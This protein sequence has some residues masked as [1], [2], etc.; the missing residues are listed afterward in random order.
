MNMMEMVLALFAVVLFTSMAGNYNRIM[1]EQ[2]DYLIN[3]TQHVQATQ[4]CHSVLDEVDAK[5]FSKQLNYE[6][7]VTAYDGLSRT[8]DLNFP[9]D[10]YQLSIAAA[11]CDSVGTEYAE[12]DS[13]AYNRLVK[14]TASTPGLREPVRMQ[15]IYLK[16]HYYN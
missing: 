2:N 7:I 16:I 5:L 3:A 15:R 6:D 1:I 9:G 14:V 4:L 8:V 12:S 13:L 10:V 11:Y